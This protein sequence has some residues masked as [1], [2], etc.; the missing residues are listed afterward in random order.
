MPLVWIA[1]TMSLHGL[2]MWKIPWNWACW[3]IYLK[4]QVQ[5]IDRV[6]SEDLADIDNDDFEIDFKQWTRTDH[7]ELISRKLPGDEF[8]NLLCEKRSL[9]IRL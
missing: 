9:L 8:I 2:L 7:T 5:Q 4:N 3:T 1:N 6:A